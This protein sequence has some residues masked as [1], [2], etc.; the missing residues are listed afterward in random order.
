MKSV[1][2]ALIGALALAGTAFAQVPS[3]NDTSDSYYNTGM[4]SFTLRALA[5]G[6]CQSPAP[7]ACFNTASGYG[8]LYSNTTGF[9][10]VASGYLALLHNT[11]GE[12]NTAVGQSALGSNTTGVENTAVGDVALPNNTT[13][14]LNVAFGTDALSQN[15][16]GSGNSALGYAALSSNTSADNNTAVGYWALYANTTG[17]GNVATGY[18]ALRTNTTASHNTADGYDALYLN[19]TG[20]QNTAVGYAALYASNGNYNAAVGFEAL[21]RNTTGDQNTGHGYGSLY[22]NTTGTNNIAEGYLAGYYLTTGSNNIDIGNR[23]VAA[24]G[25]TIR[26]GAAQTAT[27]I[28]GIYGTPVAGSPVYVS[29][30]GRLGVMVSSE[31]FKTAIA[32]M[33]SDSAKLEQLRPVTFKLKGDAKGTRQYG[34]IAEEVAKV[35]PELVIRDENGRIDGV[36]YDELAPMLLNEVQQQQKVAAAQATKIAAQDERNTVQAAE[37]RDLRQQL[38]SQAS[39]LRNAQRQI[40]ELQDLRQELHVAILGLRTKDEL[41]GRR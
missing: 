39:Q 12:G 36:R 11:T 10:N 7:V 25:N 32:R 37:I 18:Y 20:S 2:L 17:F 4:G 31:R 19:A 22:S 9:N 41:I 28:A 33:G 26:I 24:E 6:S 35:Y 14:S 21:F 3:T 5:R 8:A 34:L 15:T 30:T 23:G 38:V 29:S 16:T 40:T 1:A 13:G 27:Y